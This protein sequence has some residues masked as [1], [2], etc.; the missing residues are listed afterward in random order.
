ME[1]GSWQV[2]NCPSFCPQFIVCLQWPQGNRKWKQGD[3]FSFSPETKC[4]A[5][6]FLPETT[7]TS[8]TKSSF[9]CS[10][11]HTLEQRKTWIENICAHHLYRHG[12]SKEEKT[13]VVQKSW[14]FYCL[15]L[16]DRVLH[17]TVRSFLRLLLTPLYAFQ[18]SCNY[19][20]WKISPFN[21]PQGQ[22][23]LRSHMFTVFS[24]IFDNL[25]NWN[26]GSYD[27]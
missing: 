5:S 13:L 17:L 22:S 15:F 10:W 18:R 6:M 25:S 8:F 19:Q 20:L 26:L 3:L 12:L 9:L 23:S 27:H 21:L 1:S 11:R 2:G 7:L 16:W 24:Q 4:G 14:T